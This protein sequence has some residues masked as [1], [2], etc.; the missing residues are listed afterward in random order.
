MPHTDNKQLKVEI[1]DFK[2]KYARHFRDINRGWLEEFFTVEP[3]DRIVLEDPESEII[4]HG[5]HLLF[6]KVEGEIVGTCALLKHTESKFE[7]AKMGVLKAYRGR[8]IGRKLAEAAIAKA[9]QI[10]ADTL[11]LATSQNLEAANALYHSLG[12][13]EVSLDEIGPLPYKR[14]SIVLRLQLE[15]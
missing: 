15:E 13:Q 2:P 9:S 3:Y 4:A 10:G 1:L 7:L 11:V 14:K 6:A 8:G 12:F 5:G